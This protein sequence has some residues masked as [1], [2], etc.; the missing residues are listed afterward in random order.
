[1]GQA[2]QETMTH[3]YFNC[4]G[5]S[6]KAV[7]ITHFLTE[8]TKKRRQTRRKNYVLSQQ[9]QGGDQLILT[10]G[11]DHPYSGIRIEE[12][13]AANCRVMAHLLQT[14][15]LQATHVE[16]YLAYAV[17]IFDLAQR[18]EWETL[19]DFDYQYRDR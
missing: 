1:M 9:P 14:N 5:D 7:H 13:G 4:T 16:F 17:H 11:D 15:Q 18:Y 6:K 2:G 3:G 10:T 19:L 12:W 8:A